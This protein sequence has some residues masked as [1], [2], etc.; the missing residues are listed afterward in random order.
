MPART[1]AAATL[2]AG[3]YEAVAGSRHSHIEEPARFLGLGARCRPHR[4]AAWQLRVLDAE[5]VDAR[6]LEALRRMERQQVDTLTRPGDGVFARQ[7][8]AVE[9]LRA[10]VA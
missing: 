7:R 3:E 4:R 10:P 1:L 8:H 5:G 6:E 2:G 9:R